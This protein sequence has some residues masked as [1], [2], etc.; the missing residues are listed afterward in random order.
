MT[1]EISR[2]FSQQQYY[3]E[4]GQPIGY[5]TT[6]SVAYQSADGTTSGYYEQSQYSE[7]N[8]QGYDY[9]QQSVGFFFP[10]ND[11]VYVDF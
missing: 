3:D 11:F 5:E 7:P 2:K 10:I 6:E 1:R 4:S 8:Q 9:G